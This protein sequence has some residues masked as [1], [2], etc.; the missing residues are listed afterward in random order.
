M[1]TKIL[2]LLL[3]VLAG[4]VVAAAGVL[5]LLSLESAATLPE[6]AHLRLPTYLGAVAGFLPVLVGIG[7]LLRFLRLVDAGEAFSTP[8]V[9]VF[10]QVKLLI[11]GV[12]VYYL[13]GLV[14]FNL[15]FGQGHPGVFLA[16]LGLEIAILLLLGGFALL[17][18]LFRAAHALRQ[19]VELTV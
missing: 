17:E 7:L 9:R 15:A 8:T 13:V 12:A 18:R 16:W 1:E 6:Y 19:D 14:A 3:F 10:R 4:G 11:A 2:R 5:Y